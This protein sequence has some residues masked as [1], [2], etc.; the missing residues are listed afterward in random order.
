MQ[1]CIIKIILYKN[2]KNF[3]F[4]KN[5]PKLKTT[6]PTSSTSS[7]YYNYYYC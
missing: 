7:D 4:Q 2:N 3:S 6:T 1:Y 5:E